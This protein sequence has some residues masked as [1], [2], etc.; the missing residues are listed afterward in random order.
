MRE[1]R[2]GDP[3][4]CWWR[5]WMASLKQCWSVVL[6][7][8][9][10]HADPHSY[11][12]GP[13]PGFWISPSQNLYHLGTVG[14]HKRA[15]SADSKLQDLCDTGQQQDNQKEF[16]WRSDIVSQ[17]P[18]TS[19]QTNDSLQWTFASEDVWTEGYTVGH[20]VTYYSFHDEMFS[21]LGY[22]WWWWL[23]VCV[24]VFYFGGEVAR[25]KSAFLWFVL[26]VYFFIWDELA[27]A[28]WRYETTGRSA[29]LVCM[30]WNTKN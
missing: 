28:K 2:R 30:T 12:P 5:H 4:F 18:E 19:N 15:G 21:M 13:D 17:K 6:I 29:G 27:R 24:H 22:C 7:R 23:C 25:M 8:E 14:M 9:S 1:S 11:H 10:L 26:F 20:T 3:A 16:R